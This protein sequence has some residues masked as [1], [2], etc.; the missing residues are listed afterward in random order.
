MGVTVV[1]SAAGEPV[2]D[3]AEDGFD[4]DAEGDES[5]LPAA[6]A[7]T[8][9]DQ[10]DAPNAPQSSTDPVEPSP[11]GDPGDQRPASAVKLAIVVQRYGRAIN[12]GAELHARYLAEHLARHAEVE[13]LT[14]CAS[15]YVSWRNELHARR[16]GHQWHPGAS[17]P[18]QARA[19]PARLRTA[20]RARVSQHPLDRRRA[21][22]AG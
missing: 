21:R 2:G 12:G 19:R 11:P 6:P 7:E 5:G 22:M 18:G 4:G 3:A 10:P 15:D 9:S 14:T 13:V 17:L 1:E 16:R 8:A 20:L